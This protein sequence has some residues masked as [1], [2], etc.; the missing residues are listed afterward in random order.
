MRRDKS[1]ASPAARAARVMSLRLASFATN[2]DFVATRK[3]TLWITG[4]MS[5]RAQTALAANGWS[6][7][8]EPIP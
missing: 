6:V 3:R 1:G 4:K 5:P 8:E 2:P 7:R